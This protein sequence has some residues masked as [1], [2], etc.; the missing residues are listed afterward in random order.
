M[1]YGVVLSPEGE[2]ATDPQLELLQSFMDE[3]GRADHALGLDARL[4]LDK[5]PEAE[6][7]DWLA[8]R[9][10]LGITHVTVSPAGA[11]PGEQIEALRRFRRNARGEMI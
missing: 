3:A 8:Q 10:K 9:E 6:W 2:A 11:F 5:V 7:N 4:Y 1:R